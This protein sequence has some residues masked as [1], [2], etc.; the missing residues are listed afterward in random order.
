[1]TSV[2]MVF[3]AEADGV[4]VTGRFQDEASEESDQSRRALCMDGVWDVIE[5]AKV[6]G[7]FGLRCATV[8][9]NFDEERER[10]LWNGNAR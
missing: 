5:R 9:D 10:S 3:R 6:T 4:R 7:T 1:M 2:W 8:G